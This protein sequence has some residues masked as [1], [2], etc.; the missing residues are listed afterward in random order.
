MAIATLVLFD[1]DGTL[2]S[3][4]ERELNIFGQALEK[5]F[6]D[7]GP[8]DGYSFAGKTDHQIVVDLLSRVGKN[9]SEIEAGL[10]AMQEHYFDILDGMLAQSSMAVL[11]GVVEL[12]NGLAA[13][14]SVILG[15]QTGNWRRAAE[16]KLTR[17]GL[18]HYF[19]VGAFGDGQLDRLGLPPLACRRA[20]EATGETIGAENTV[21]IGDT[22]L[23]VACARSSGMVSIGVATG[24]TGRDE[25]EEAG[26]DLVVSTLAE[27]DADELLDLAR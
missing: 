10:P 12:L 23:D 7:I 1:I 26:A 25:L 20:V 13:S 2:L 3:I 27:I 22:A 24:S 6:G 19:D 21:I 8:L 15:L 11:P 4:A 5:V 16:I 9:A 18:G 14:R 17:Y